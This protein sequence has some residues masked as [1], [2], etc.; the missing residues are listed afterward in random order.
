MNILF[1]F[2]IRSSLSENLWQ[3][4]EP[5]PDFYE[6]LNNEYRPCTKQDFERVN[7][8]HIWEQKHLNNHYLNLIC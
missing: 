4:I 3:P 6:L 7:G 5:P 2:E 8:L 1:Y